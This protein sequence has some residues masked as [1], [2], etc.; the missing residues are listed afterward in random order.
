[1]SRRDSLHKSNRLGIIPRLVKALSRAVTST[2]FREVDIVDADNIP[3]DRGIIFIAWHPSGLID[4]M[5]VHSV[6]EG[7]VTMV[8][9]HS[10][11]KIPILGWLIRKAGAIP[12]YRRGDK[13]ADSNASKNEGALSGVA[14]VIANGG[15]LL[16]FPEGTSHSD[17][18]VRKGKTGT[19]RIIF[20]AMK[21]ANEKGF[22]QPLIIPVGLHYSDSNTFRERCAVI[23]ERPMQLPDLPDQG[24]DNQQWVRDVT[25]D[26]QSELRR[27]SL[28]KTS[29]SDRDLIWKARSA[30]HA[31][32]ARASGEKISKASYSESILGARRLRAGWEYLSENDPEKCKELV[33]E[34]QSHFDEL[35]TLG[36]H[37]FDVDA[38]PKNMAFGYQ[39]VLMAKWLWSAAW[40]L[41]LVTWGAVI[42]NVPPYQAN[43]AL[44]WGL[45]KKG[46][47]ESAIGS[48]KVFSSFILFPVWWV[49]ASAG[50]TW[51]LLGQDS[52]VNALLQ[53][54]WLLG[55]LVSLPPLLV[56]AIFFIW[57]PVA[58]RLH[59]K[60]FERL[61]VS[62]RGL[63]RW[64]LWKSKSYDW[65]A[66]QDRQQAIATSLLGVSA[67]LVLPGDSEWADP[68]TGLDDYTAVVKR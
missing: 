63:R 52:P 22:E 38:R 34:C 27:A 17:P 23:F 56:G 59:L 44:L 10:L 1:M 47:Q 5:L 15:K 58:G 61:V 2:W 35:E 64:R 24:E 6:V 50:A 4:P 19:A 11:F 65:Q 60:L 68:S 13:G 54:H 8:A 18:E 55:E 36:L 49:V 62:Y 66:L 37:P 40:M 53:M 43:Y 46:I 31:E 25:E 28:S 33:D 14:K 16:I 39:L 26:I 20:Q 29:W 3:D 12:I 67:G 32:R 45:K 42:G 51:L 9:K 41:G 48:V 30:V 57:W 7:K 21:L